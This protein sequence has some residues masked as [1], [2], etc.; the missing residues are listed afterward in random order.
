MATIDS[1]LNDFMKLDYNTREMLLEILQKR[2][3][4]SRRNDIA[5]SAKKSLKEFQQ[6]KLKPESAENL[7]ARLQGL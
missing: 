5:K 3:I 6:G 4:E 1:T 7:I 2:Q